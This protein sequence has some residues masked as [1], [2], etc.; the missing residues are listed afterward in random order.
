MSI[1]QNRNKIN[2]NSNRE[3]R[4]NQNHDTDREYLGVNH[5]LYHVKM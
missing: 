5:H 4:E 2:K 3:P 1:T